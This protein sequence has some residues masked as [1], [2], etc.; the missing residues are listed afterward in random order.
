MGRP[1]NDMGA[2]GRGHLRASHADREQV[3]GTLKAAFVAGMLAKDEFD[4]RVGQTLA[5]RTFAELAAL[6]ADLPAGLTAARPP[7]PARARGR[8]RVLRPGAVLTAATGLYAA[9]WLVALLLPRDGEGESMAAVNLAVMSTFV[10]ATVVVA[11]WTQMLDSRREKRSG[12]RLPPGPAP[13]AGG[14]ASRHPPSAGPDRQLPQAGHGEQ[15]ITEAAPGRRRRTP[16]PV[17]R[18]RLSMSC[19]R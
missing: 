19:V 11:A 16:L 13:G 1:G 4:L 17:W 2:G 18:A 9:L 8:A 14:Q 5:S 15:R 6:T 7:Q 12:R 3:I 10:Y